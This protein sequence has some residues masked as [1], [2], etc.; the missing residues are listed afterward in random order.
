M[1]TKKRSPAG[2]LLPRMGWLLPTDCESCGGAAEV[3]RSS[4]VFQAETFR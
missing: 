3:V 1:M 2:E 4:G